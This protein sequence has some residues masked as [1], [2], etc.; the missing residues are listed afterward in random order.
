[1][2]YSQKD[3]KKLGNI[4][5]IW[6]HPDDEIF[7]AAGLMNYASNNEQKIISITA[8]Y[9]D[10]G[11]T[12]DEEKWPKD[13]LG[14][15]RKTESDNALKVIGNIEQ[16]WLGYKDGKLKDVDSDEALQKIEEIIKG[17]KI[18]TIISFESEGITGHDDHKTVHKWAKYLA[19]KLDIKLYCA[20]ENSDFYERHG[21][22][23]HKKHNI[24][25]NTEKPNLVT[26]KDADICLELDNETKDTKIKAIKAHASQTAGM[27]ESE[28][29]KKALLAMVECECFVHS[30]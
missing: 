17:R 15:I 27:I 13:K 22:E 10:A 5:G 11:E 9:G 12:A 24:Y 16:H 14:E 7:S 18:D 28:D 19:D 1:M 29:S 20:M 26:A 2:V 3:L 30:A 21:K 25:F 8:T 4:L 6:A 23:L